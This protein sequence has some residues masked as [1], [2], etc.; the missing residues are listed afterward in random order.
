[1]PNPKGPP[2]PRDWG[3]IDV[4]LSRARRDLWDSMCGGR[5]TVARE[6]ALR[7]RDLADEMLHSIEQGTVRT[8]AAGSG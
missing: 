1:M 2:P 7:L 8:K 3:A 5:V 6:R 4:D